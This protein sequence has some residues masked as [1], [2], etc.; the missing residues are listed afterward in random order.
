MCFYWLLGSE[1]CPQEESLPASGVVLDLPCEMDLMEEFKQL[2]QIQGG[3]EHAPS[4]CPAVRSHI[5]KD[6]RGPRLPEWIWPQPS[7]HV[8]ENA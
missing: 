2:W 4:F 8:C 3:G 1:S 6:K 7:I 5:M